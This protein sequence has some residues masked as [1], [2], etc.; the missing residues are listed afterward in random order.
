MR[1]SSSL[2][3]ITRLLAKVNVMVGYIPTD[4]RIPSLKF[5]GGFKVRLPS[6]ETDDLLREFDAILH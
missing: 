5:G 2:L 1:M 6:R 4:F 3:L